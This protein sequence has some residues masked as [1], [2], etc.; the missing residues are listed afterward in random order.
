MR[1]CA[2]LFLLLF[3][4]SAVSGLLS[5][6]LPDRAV[7][8]NLHQLLW[9][10]CLLTGC[11][12]YIGLG[13]NRHLPVAVLVLPM[14]WLVWSLIFWWPLD[15]TAIS[16]GG[17]ATYV[18]QL[19]MAM[20]VLKMNLL[21]NGRS[22]LLVPS[23]FSGS[24]FSLRRLLVFSCISLIVV[25]ATLAVIL[26]ATA[27]HLLQTSTAGFVQ[28]RPDGLY[29]TEKI[30]HRDDKQI[31]LAGMIHLGQ[32]SYYHDLIASI[33]AEKTLILAEGVSDEANLLQY[34]FNYHRVADLFGLSTQEKFPFAGRLISRDELDKPYREAFDGPHI[35]PADIDLQQFDPRTVEVLNALAR[36]VLNSDSLVSGYLEFNRWAEKNMTVDINRV[37]MN[38]LIAKRN[39]ALLDL[40]PP[41]LKHYERLVIPWG[42]LHMKG[43][44]E[45]VKQAGFYLVVS[46]SRR[47]IRFFDL[48]LSSLLSEF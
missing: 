18:G 42:A 26:F 5:Q 37:V 8:H 33:P 24:A 14:L 35:L 40:L 43:I 34:A 11:L 44:E 1:R 30:Y 16:W 46:T 15:L 17:T 29:M 2:N 20:I 32:Q 22:L 19:L 38:D 7:I 36:Y 25:P 45:E 4:L 31:R 48:D 27:S 47:S 21:A 39:R 9:I 28:L 6:L 23:Q 41:A 12:V 13:V 10:S 3:A